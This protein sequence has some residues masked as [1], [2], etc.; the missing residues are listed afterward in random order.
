MCHQSVGLIARELEAAGIPT[1]CMS[2]AL[3]I[4]QAVLPPRAVF[5]DFPL[6]HTSGK[7]FA[8]EQQ[9]SLLARTL[10]AFADI[11]AAGEIRQFSDCW[12][13]NDDWKIDVLNPDGDS[14]TER[15][16]GPQYQL[17]ADR[18]AAEAALARDGCPTCIWVGETS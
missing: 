4:T 13:S 15:A 14:R 7:P 17:E 1:L 6:G 11:H 3:S 9:D 12:A 2:S 16:D 10:A 5:V 18:Q 8:P